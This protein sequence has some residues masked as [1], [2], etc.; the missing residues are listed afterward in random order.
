[1]RQVGKNA[2]FLELAIQI[3]FNRVALRI[4]ARRSMKLGAHYLNIGI[5][6]RHQSPQKVEVAFIELL[7]CSDVGIEPI[8]LRSKPEVSGYPLRDLLQRRGVPVLGVPL[9]ARTLQCVLCEHHEVRRTAR[10]ISS[11]KSRNLTAEDLS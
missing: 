4:A 1:M 8:D 9:H 6:A 11:F 5:V 10:R 3:D 7:L 2:N